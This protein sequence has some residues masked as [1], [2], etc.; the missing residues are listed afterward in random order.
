MEKVATGD[1]YG[2]EVKNMGLLD[3]LRTSDDYLLSFPKHPIFEVNYEIK[4]NWQD[5]LSH[6]LGKLQK[7]SHQTVQSFEKADFCKSDLESL[8]GLYGLYWALK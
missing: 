3:E 8:T 5:K 2:E 7:N 1:W 6:I 4:E